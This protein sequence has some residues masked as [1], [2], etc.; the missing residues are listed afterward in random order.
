MCHPAFHV[1]PRLTE[2]AESVSSRAVI[3]D[4][5]LSPIEEGKRER[6]FVTARRAA[7][8]DDSPVQYVG[9]LYFVAFRL[10][11]A[12]YNP[13]PAAIAFLAQLLPIANTGFGVLFQYEAA[14]LPES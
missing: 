7:A 1:V 3:V 5:C 10:Y 8:D 9:A 14:D 4:V 11:S 12:L 13:G 2:A 6:V